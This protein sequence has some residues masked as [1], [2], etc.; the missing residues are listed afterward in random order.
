MMLL[1]ALLGDVKGAYCVLINVPER[2][3]VRV[4]SLGHIDFAPGIYVYVGSALAG[5]E[6]RIA[7]H[8]RR[9]K[10]SR[11]HIDYLMRHAEYLSSIVVPCDTKAVECY[12]AKAL[13]QARGT[14]IPVP[15]F[16]SSDCKCGSH[17]LYFGDLDPEWVAESI[18]FRLAML[19][20]V[21]LADHEGR[22]WAAR[23]RQ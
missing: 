6:H 14:V 12:L 5:V 21:Y 11:W 9:V 22:P 18:S 7:R 16:G 17:L 1:C 2:C 10:K 19:E 23:D 4:G 20:C 13:V 8:A 3:K 15:G